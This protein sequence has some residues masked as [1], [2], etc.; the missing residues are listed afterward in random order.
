MYLES[1]RT[2]RWSFFAKIDWVLNAPL[3]RFSKLA[4]KIAFS[5]NKK[6]S[7]RS[8]LKNGFPES[9]VKLPGKQL[10]W[11]SLLMKMLFFNL[12]IT[13][14]VV[15]VFWCN[16]KAHIHCHFL[17]KTVWLLSEKSIL[18]KTTGHLSFTLL[19]VEL[20]H[21][22]EMILLEFCYTTFLT[23]SRKWEG[24]GGCYKLFSSTITHK[25]LPLLATWNPL[26]FHV[27]SSFL[28]DDFGNN[29]VRW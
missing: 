17:R 2:S 6:K 15:S 18:S 21:I 20:L 11:S 12:F 22:L 24:V 4:K 3:Y 16:T 25:F 8:I 13:F 28:I 7:P 23:L 29:F 1:S 14:E 5:I 9:F 26:H 27:D 10:W 19:K